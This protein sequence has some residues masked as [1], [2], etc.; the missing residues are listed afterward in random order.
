MNAIERYIFRTTLGAFVLVLLSLTGVIWLT[1]ALKDIDLMTN[2]GQSVLVFVGIT[3]M[4]IP[5]LML[6]IAPVALVVAVSYVLNKLATDSEIIVMN[7]AGMSPWRLFRAFILVGLT[8]SVMVTIIAA[9]LAPK[10]LRELRRWGEEVRADLV[11]NIVQP[12]RFTRIEANLVFHIRERQSNGLL[13][14][15]F[16]DDQRDPKEQ[17][18]FL[19]ETG[20]I[21][22]SQ[23]N[24]YLL[25]ANGSVQ[26]LEAGQRDPTMVT[27]EKYAFDLSRFGAAPTV[28]YTTRERYFWEL[29][30]PTDDASLLG[31]ADQ[32]RAELHDRITSALYP[33]A[34]VVIAFAYL[35]APRTTRQSRA[36][37]M[38]G[39]IGMVMLVRMIG[40]I[41]VVVGVRSPEALLMPYLAIATVFV[42]GYFI[43][44]RGLIIEPPAFITD[45][46][47]RIGERF[48]RVAAAG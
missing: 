34:F 17:A 43:I 10:G 44:A 3:S 41:G 35:G 12:G 45:A 31:D 1:Q 16:L 26:R 8:V 48:T 22:K 42:A 47:T 19:A 4:V 37:S 40:M 25:L 18:T 29:I 5:L 9:Y 20:E 11:A 21:I 24:T 33:L 13:L 15:I 30:L 28:R 36:L 23:G 2:Q 7:A 27:F 39:A 14:G 6:I 46:I 32:V 38:L